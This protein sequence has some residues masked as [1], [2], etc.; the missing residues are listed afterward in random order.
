VTDLAG[1][2]RKAD[3]IEAAAFTDL[4][5]A[6]PPELARTAGLRVERVA[7][8]TL[9]IAPPLPA[10]SFNR[11]IGLGL[12]QPAS[13]RDLD[14]I[15]ATYRQAGC[16]EFWIHLGP[17]AQPAALAGWVAAR[18]FAPPKRRSSA[19]MLH[20]GK[21]LP[22]IATSMTVRPASDPAAFAHIVGTAFGMP[23]AVGAW[24]GRLIGRPGW[25]AWFACNGDSPVS[26]GA[27][28][29]HGGAGWLGLGATLPDFR[30]HG[31]QG[32]LMLQRIRAAQAA[33]CAHIF[34]ETGEPIADEPNP[35]LDNMYRC[36]F[37]KVCS[38][39]NYA[40]TL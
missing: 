30:R 10:H 22:E 16:R 40:M 27:L 3:A 33:G 8:A 11:V 12:Q 31:G 37:E 9:L 17:A 24:L 23:P 2:A 20:A 5:A 14:A 26:A 1:L 39:L 4:F 35:S 18:G 15:V 32:A 38:R 34:T 7:D 21:A 19:K 36:G 13:E 29:I 28:Y 25:Q 6:A